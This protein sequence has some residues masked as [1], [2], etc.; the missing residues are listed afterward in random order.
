MKKRLHIELRG[1]SPHLGTETEGVSLQFFAAYAIRLRDAYRRSAQGVVSGVIQDE[2][3]LPTRAAQVDIRLKEAH[4]GSLSMECA[5]VDMRSVMGQPMLIDDHLA[6]DAL[7]RFM[8]GLEQAARAP[9]SESIPRAFRV[10]IGGVGSEIQQTYAL[11]EGDRVLR[12]ISLTSAGFDAVPDPVLARVERLPAIVKGVTFSPK[13]TVTLEIEGASVRA[14]AT[15]K[16]V[17]KAFELHDADNIVATIVTNASG[18]RLLD[19][20]PAEQ[21]FPK[22]VP[23]L[24]ETLDRFAGVLRIL[25]E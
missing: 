24:D 7:S 12:S 16:L 9:D 19:I 14:S 5:A 17:K 22:R 4:E 23:E 6:E 11:K 8:D 3:R 15:E 25:A 13:L 20:A 10:L 2:G 18:A 21:S 1:A